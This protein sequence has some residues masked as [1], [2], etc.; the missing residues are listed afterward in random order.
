MGGTCLENNH[1][2]TNAINKTMQ[3]DVCVGISNTHKVAAGTFFLLHAYLTCVI[4]PLQYIGFWQRIWPFGDFMTSGSGE[5]INPK[6]DAAEKSR[7]FLRY[8][9]QQLV[10]K[11]EGIFSVNTFFG[12]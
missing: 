11:K 8:V 3:D 6:K 1:N 2:Y 9:L 5:I 4:I 12:Q 10:T 7:V